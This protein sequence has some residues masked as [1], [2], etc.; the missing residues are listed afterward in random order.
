M[1]P[2]GAGA[3]GPYPHYPQQP[4]HRRTEPFAIVSLVASI[5]GFGFCGVG[6]IVGIVFGHIARSRIKKSCDEGAGMALAGIIVGYA[7]IAL[8]VGA[9][10]IIGIVGGFDGDP[11]TDSSALRLADNIAYTADTIGSTPRDARVVHL[12]IRSG[13]F[14]DDSV[15]VGST[16]LEAVDATDGELAAQG[17]RLE[18]HNGTFGTACLWLSHATTATPRIDSGPCRAIGPGADDL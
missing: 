12:A 17:W 15:L 3:P 6:Q 1:P 2:P 13:R 18:V 10:A 5:A 11:G 16:D 8:V 7:T 9:I 4:P 14:P